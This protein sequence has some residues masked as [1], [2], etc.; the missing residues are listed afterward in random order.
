M[1]NCQDGLKSCEN[2]HIDGVTDKNSPIT[3]TPGF[4]FEQIFWRMSFPS[5]FLF[6]VW[7]RGDAASW[8]RNQQTIDAYSNYS[9]ANRKQAGKEYAVKDPCK[10]TPCYKETICTRCCSTMKGVCGKRSV[11]TD[12]LLQRDNLHM[13]L[14]TDDSCQ[15]FSKKL[16][17]LA[18]IKLFICHLWLWTKIVNTAVIGMVYGK[19]SQISCI[20]S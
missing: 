17:Y 20:D 4:R 12:T 7:N 9:P 5:S 14:F 8:E 3:Y 10:P 15:C 16:E 1:P 13:Q 6:A 18:M 2:Q 19:M 11:Q